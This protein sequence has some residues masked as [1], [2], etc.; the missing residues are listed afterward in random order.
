MKPS[1]SKNAKKSVTFGYFSGKISG[2]PNHCSFQH[3]QQLTSQF[4]NPKHSHPESL[5]N[6][7]HLKIIRQNWTSLSKVIEF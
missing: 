2:V 5:T 3:P 1:G 4:P 7:L 6:N